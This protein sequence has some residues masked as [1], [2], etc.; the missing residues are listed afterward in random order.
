MKT[1]YHGQRVNRS[2]VGR[3][4]SGKLFQRPD[5]HGPGYTER[6]KHEA[7]WALWRLLPINARTLDTPEQR[8]I[9]SAQYKRIRR[10]GRD[11]RNAAAS[12]LGRMDAREAI[13]ALTAA[14]RC[15][16]LAAFH[17][18]DGPACTCPSHQ[19]PG[20]RRAGWSR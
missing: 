15:E 3:V 10:M 14:Q 6:P 2:N 13:A 8:T 20:M 12:A 16:P 18:S 17:G 5:F 4:Q 1:P 19:W 9:H 11:S 7:R